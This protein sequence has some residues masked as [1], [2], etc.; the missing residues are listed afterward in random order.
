MYDPNTRSGKL[1]FDSPI[2]KIPDQAFDYCTNLKWIDIP[3]SIT[4]IGAGAFKDCYNIERLTVPSTVTLI[5]PSA[6]E[7]CT[8]V[9]TLYCNIPAGNI[10]DGSV[11]RTSKFSKIIIGEGMTKIPSLAF[12]GCSSI[13]SITIPNGVKTIE[14][15]AFYN[16]I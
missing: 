7:N 8:G 6:F 4:S 10:N 2:S 11:F 16:C 14:S 3:E 13:E 12:R 1:I 15:G 5:N 9:L